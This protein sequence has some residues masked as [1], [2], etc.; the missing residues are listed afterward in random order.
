MR[1][2]PSWVRLSVYRNEAET[3][4]PVPSDLVGARPRRKVDLP[5]FPNN[6]FLFRHPPP[7]ASL[8]VLSG[9][10][11]LAVCLTPQTKVWGVSDRDTVEK[12]SDSF[13]QKFRQSNLLLLDVFFY[14]CLNVSDLLS[15][16]FTV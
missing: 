2:P 13:R 3:H 5:A 12:Q 11:C 16:F 6:A 8:A 10:F 4:N 9:R 7:P 15:G 1:E 14:T